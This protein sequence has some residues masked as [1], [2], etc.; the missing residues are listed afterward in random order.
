MRCSDTAAVQ[1]VS[2]VTTIISIHIM[3]TQDKRRRNW[4]SFVLPRGKDA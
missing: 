2:P 4:D 3:T 1:I